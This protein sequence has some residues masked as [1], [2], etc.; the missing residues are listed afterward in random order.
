VISSSTVANCVLL[1]DTTLPFSR[2][3]SKEAGRMANKN[4]GTRGTNKS[5]VNKLNAR[6]A[7]PYVV[8][9]RMAQVGASALTIAQK[10]GRV[11]KG[12]DKTH[13]IRAILSGMRTKGWKDEN[14]KL[15]KL[16][17]SRVGQKKDKTSAIKP[18]K[19]KKKT[20]TKRATPKPSANGSTT[21]DGKT[22]VAGGSQ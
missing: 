13:T 19:A 10:V 12:D 7:I 15:Q 20:I 18:Q 22:L 1:V 14:G 21:P 6:R 4:A 5:L 17:V 8:I 11:N 3:E 16:K 9:A 2:S